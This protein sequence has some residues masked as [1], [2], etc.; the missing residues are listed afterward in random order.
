MS[1]DWQ[2]RA[3]AAEQRAQE[4][5]QRAMQL[6]DATNRALQEL[7][8]L[9]ALAQRMELARQERASYADAANRGEA[10]ALYT[11]EHLC[12]HCV[13]GHVCELAEVAARWEER[14]PVVWR[15]AAFSEAEGAGESFRA[16]AG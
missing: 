11:E 6:R 3:L 15:C 1:I 16:A 9:R 12:V 4:A 13:H 10:A 14:F 5:E 8:R 2:A 7:P